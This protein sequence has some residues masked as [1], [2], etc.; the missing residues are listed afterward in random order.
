MRARTKTILSLLTLSAA[1]LAAHAGAP[2]A[3]DR[4]PADTDVVVSI[5][6]VADFLSDLDQINRLLGD[7]ASP[8]LMFAAAMVRG[9]PGMNLDGSAVV[10]VDLPDDPNAG[11]EPTGVVLLPVSDFAAFTQGR[12]PVDGLVEMPFPDQQVFARDLG[13]GLVALSNDADAV[14]AYDATKGN[15]KAHASR[16]GGAGNRLLDGS[17]VA[18]LMN[19]NSMRPYLDAVIEGMKEQGA[20]VG[21]M[22]GEQAAVGYNTFLSIVTTGLNDLAAGAFGLSVDDKGMSYDMA[23]NFTE[24]SASAAKFAKGGKTEGLVSHLPAGPYMFAMSLDTSAPGVKQIA[25]AVNALTANLP[26]EMRNQMGM[27]FGQMS[28]KDLTELTNGVAFVMGSTPGL[29]GGGLFANTTQYISTD[30]PGAYRQAMMTLMNETN[31]KSN[32]GVTVETSVS[33]DAVTI[34]GVALTS[35]GVTFKVDPNAMQGMGAMPID[36]TM[37][38]QMMFGPTGGPAGYLGEVEGGII[39]TLTQGPEL[40]KRAITAAKQGKGLTTN[41]GL[42]RVAAAMPADR[43]AE[44]YIGVDEILNAV[45]PM[46]MM[47]GA[48]P[49]FEPVD[50]L[51]PIGL[52]MTFDDGGF[53]GRAHMPNATLQKIMTMMPEDAMNGEGGDDEGF[54]F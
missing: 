10:V 51:D 34:D 37:M 47:F 14:R 40:T 28:L 39:Q 4:V 24:G 8:Q 54:D 25:E 19:A 45:G 50:A 46:M 30:K 2:D 36:P 21:M 1:S 15:M 6:K 20:M 12:D 32:E 35:Y 43:A 16:L 18:I 23:M 27:G 22:G 49:E 41:A 33:P 38:M 31:G 52:A 29:M 3:L 17:E 44:I 53:V 26:A 13:A 11:T 9:M 48:I 7:N 42:A 5:G